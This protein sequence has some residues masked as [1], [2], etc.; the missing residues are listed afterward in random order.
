MLLNSFHHKIQALVLIIAFT[1]CLSCDDGNIVVS[2][3]N[4]DE[5]TTLSLCQQDD[6]NVLYFIDS[7]TNEAIS[8]KFPDEDFDA[9]FTGLETIQTIEIDINSDNQ[10]NYRKLGS[11]AN[12]SNYFCQQIP[13]SSPDVVEEFVST[14]GGKAFLEIRI[15]NQDDDDDVPAEL[16]D[17][18]GNGDLFDDDTDGDGIPNFLDT[19]DD[20]DNVLT[21]SEKLVAVDDNGVEITD[22]NGDLVYVDTDNDGN[23]NYLDNDDDGDGVLTINEDLNYCEDPENPALNP[24]ND[25]NA[26]GLPNYLNP[27]ISESVEVNVVKNNNISRTFL[28]QVVFTDITFEN[29]NNDESL[30]FTTFIMGR[31]QTTVSQDLPYN[32][33]VISQDE[34]DNICQ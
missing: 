34:V 33:T 18:N 24:G 19:D 3:F 26:D 14:T 15:T 5:N 16:E 7:E 20:N 1:L 25:L 28:T 13:P 17:I 11:S 8:F 22:E 9:T 4:F 10:V 2:S 21:K 23:L 12:G 6:V 27:D 31:F 29:V 30:S 32:D